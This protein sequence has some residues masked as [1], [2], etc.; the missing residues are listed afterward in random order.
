MA[1]TDAETIEKFN[2]QVN[3]SV[4]ELETWLDSD[5]SQQAGTGVGHESGRK[6]VEIL[7]KNPN[8]D[9]KIYDAVSN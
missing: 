9:A 1:I 6:I 3:M 2:E 7:K 4:E 8:R 5:T